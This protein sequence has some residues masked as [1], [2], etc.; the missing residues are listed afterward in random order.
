M[1]EEK[2]TSIDLKDTMEYV[3]A[4]KLITT[5]YNAIVEDGKINFDDAKH[6]MKLASEYKVFVNAI[7]DSGNVGAELKDLGEGEL[8]ML[9]SE[10]FG[11]IK[12][13]SKAIKKSVAMGKAA[14]AAPK[15]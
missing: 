15:K 4:L 9:G 7:K 6:F 5:Q 8:L 1:S 11:I 12:G 3:A 13:M 2:V 14:K 10:V